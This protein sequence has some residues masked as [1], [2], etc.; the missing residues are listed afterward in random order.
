MKT[1]FDRPSK[2]LYSLPEGSS[3][4]FS[5]SLKYFSIFNNTLYPQVEQCTKQI[6]FLHIIP[7][8][9]IVS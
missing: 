9:V 4:I 2:I 8:G 5:I 6:I 1:Y 3:K 7:V